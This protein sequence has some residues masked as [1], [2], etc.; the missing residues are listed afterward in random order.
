VSN[1]QRVVA[2]SRINNSRTTFSYVLC[3]QACRCDKQA[4]L[5][6]YKK[7]EVRKET[8]LNKERN[9]VEMDKVNVQVYPTFVIQYQKT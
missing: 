3:L 9:N 1:G 2:G 4:F 8:A 7:D 6:Q 5:G